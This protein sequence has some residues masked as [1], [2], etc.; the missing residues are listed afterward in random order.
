MSFFGRKRELELL[1][2][3]WRSDRA[4]FIPIYGRRRVGKSELILHFMSGKDGLY[5][6]GKRAPGAAQLQEFLEAAARAVNEP[7]LAQSR[8]GTWKAALE[9]VMERRK[10]PGKL[11]LA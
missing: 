6:M 10:G 11:I 1:Q 7:L 9:A 3:A 5:F 8:I 2:S 4:A